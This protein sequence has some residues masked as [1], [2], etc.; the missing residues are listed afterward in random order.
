MATLLRLTPAVKQRLWPWYDPSLLNDTRVLR[1]S[2]FGKVFGW[3][4]QAGVTVNG[5]VHLTPRAHDLES[6]AGTALL[7][8][9]L[10]HVVQQ[11][12]MGWWRYLLRYLIRWRPKHISRGWEHPMEAPAYARGSEVRQALS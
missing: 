3:S 5:V 11:R 9:E 12:E 6:A 2:L 10:F 7:A 4:G 8:H 1:G